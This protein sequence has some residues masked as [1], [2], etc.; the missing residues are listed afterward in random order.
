MAA[1]RKVFR[2]EEL[3]TAQPDPVAEGADAA[4]RHA[5][6]MREMVT[7]RAALAAR[8][9]SPPVLHESDT[10]RAGELQRLKGEL[11][12]I[13]DAITRTKHE[14]AALHVSSFNGE[15]MTRASNELDAVMGGTEQATQKILAAAE[16][17]DQAANTLSASLKNEFEQG[18]TQ[19][20]QD[21]VIQIF[22]ACNFQDVTGQRITKVAATL[23]F[24]EEHVMR[25]IEIWGGLKTDKSD[26]SVAA[27]ERAVIQLLHGPRL[28]DD[29][30]HASQNDINLM[31]G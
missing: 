3:V 1:P 11:Q 16:E 9:S 31:F 28:D 13:H 14:L 2:I 21:R 12:L 27:V 22:E 24:I 29:D 6:V 25:M 4:L 5:E 23:K 26:D 19:D 10:R 17:I 8:A 15:S 18:L 20:I 7:L 30:G